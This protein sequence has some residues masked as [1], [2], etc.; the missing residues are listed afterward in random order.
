MD[1]RIQNTQRFVNVKEYIFKSSGL[2]CTISAL[3]FEIILSNSRCW[4]LWDFDNKVVQ[5]VC[6]GLWQIYYPQDFNISGSMTRMLVYTPITS[7]WTM[8]LEFQ[9][10]QDLIMWAI[11][12]KTIVLIF[13]LVAIKIS[14]M[15]DPFT[16]IEFFC[17]RMSAIILGVSSIL[18]FVAVTLNHLVD[19]YG[20]TTFDFPPYFPVKKEDI[21]KKH[22]TIVFPVGVLTAN[23][24]LFGAIMFLYE[25]SSL[26]VQ[27][28]VKAKCAP[29]LAEQKA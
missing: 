17:Y 25:M 18:T 20:H 3:V 26:T 7:T 29:K 21:I 8:S 28:Q 1:L 23:M 16:E 24:S 15:N 13:S 4:R 27:S 22:C 12:M 5:F 6:I 11:L 19:I 10:S 14:S 2:L 9:C